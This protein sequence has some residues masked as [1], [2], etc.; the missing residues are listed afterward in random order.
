AECINDRLKSMDVKKN[1]DT[2]EAKN[3]GPITPIYE[4]RSPNVNAGQA[5]AEEPA[6]NIDLNNIV[7]TGGE[8]KTAN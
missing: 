3:I 8:W 7:L 1:E 5:P 4:E 2:T 6:E